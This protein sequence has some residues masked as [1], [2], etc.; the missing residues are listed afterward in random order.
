[1]EDVRARI[2]DKLSSIKTNKKRSGLIMPTIPNFCKYIPIKCHCTDP[3]ACIISLRPLLL[4]WQLRIIFHQQTL[5]QPLTAWWHQLVSFW[6]WLC[7]LYTGKRQTANPRNFYI[8]SKLRLT[9]DVGNLTVVLHAACLQ[10][11]PV[12]SRFISI[13]VNKR[14]S[15]PTRNIE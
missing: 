15:R 13:S 10:A 5:L 12:F 3:V 7:C 2:M 6:C 4:Q 11:L 9:V 8:Y 14:S 1:M